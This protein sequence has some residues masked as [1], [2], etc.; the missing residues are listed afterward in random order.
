M[1]DSG[2]RRRVMS[3][4]GERRRERVKENMTEFHGPCK[5]SLA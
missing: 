2:E 4:S 1:S 3:D 5:A